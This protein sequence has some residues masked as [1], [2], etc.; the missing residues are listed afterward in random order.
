[1]PS[2]TFYASRNGLFTRRVFE[3]GRRAWLPLVQARQLVIT[4]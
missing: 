3:P 1:M 2:S 4:F